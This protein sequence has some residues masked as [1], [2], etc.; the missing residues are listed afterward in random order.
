MARSSV[1]GPVRLVSVSGEAFHA[2][3]RRIEAVHGG[4]VLVAG[5]SPTWFGYLPEP[6]REGYEE[7]M[8]LGP[9]AVIAVAAAL[10]DG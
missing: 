10:T 3:G 2:L 7:D 9:E 1:M 5:L 4:R 6:Y 8:S